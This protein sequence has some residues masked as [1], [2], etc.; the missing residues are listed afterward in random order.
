[1]QE[2][3]FQQLLEEAAATLSSHQGEVSLP[4]DRLR[5]K[6]ASSGRSQQPSMLLAAYRSP[7]PMKFVSLGCTVNRI[8]MGLIFKLDGKPT[9]ATTHQFYCSCQ[10]I[11]CS[12]DAR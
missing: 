3:S 5:K 11:D 7:E 1:L 10:M 8:R 6:V 2:E 12:N 9:I 4:L